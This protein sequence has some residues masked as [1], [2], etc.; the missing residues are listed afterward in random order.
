[1]EPG[2][3]TGSGPGAEPAQPCEQEPIAH[4]TIKHLAITA[5]LLLFTDRLPTVTSMVT[6][7]FYTGCSEP[8]ACA[9][10]AGVRLRQEQELSKGDDHG[11][12]LS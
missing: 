1:M 3:R 4:P 9:I 7:Q 12:D 6:R 5:V 10:R 8:T 11:D 2:R